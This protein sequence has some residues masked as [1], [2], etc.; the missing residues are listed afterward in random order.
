MCLVSFLD[1]D[2]L[3]IVLCIFIVCK[4]SE[5]VSNK[6]REQA[7]EIAENLLPTKSGN[8][9][10]KRYEKF[11]KWKKD[12][13]IAPNNFSEVVLLAYFSKLK[14]RLFHLLVVVLSSMNIFDR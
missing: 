13:N 7:N 11:V 4:M 2:S 1:C 3:K 6:I 9:Y 5:E 12:E 8:I 10:M 14:G